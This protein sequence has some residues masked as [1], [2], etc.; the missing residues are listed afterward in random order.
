MQITITIKQLG[1][2]HSQFQV[3]N[4]DVDFKKN[5]VT[6][7]ELIEK[8][9]E[10]QVNHFLNQSFETDDEDKIHLPK[11]N[12][13]PILLDTG[14]TSFGALYNPKKP[15]LV[16]AQETAVQAFEDGIFTIFYGEDQLNLISETIDLTKQKMFTFIRLTFLAGSYW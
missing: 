7:K 4:I 5:I 13:L 11:D 16:Q 2:K 8:I 3:R 6:A 1:K 14:K 15:N 9:V 10:N 12:Y